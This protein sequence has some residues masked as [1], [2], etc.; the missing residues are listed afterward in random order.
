M[1]SQFDVLAPM[2]LWAREV[3]GVAIGGATEP[4]YV[5]CEDARGKRVNVVLKLRDPGKPWEKPWNL[6]LVRDLVG[7]IIA[8][9]LGLNVPDYA[10][11][12]LDEDFIRSTSKHPAG[13]RISRNT[14]WNFGLLRIDAHLEA[15]EGSPGDWS[16]VLSFDA[17][18]FNGDRQLGNP[19][20]LWDG[21]RLYVIDHGLLAPTWTFRV[22]QVTSSTL[23]GPSRIRQHAGF[24]M[25]QSKHEPYPTHAAAWSSRITAEFLTWL[26]GQVPRT[27]AGSQDVDELFDFLGARATIA[28]MQA[29]ELCS[30]VA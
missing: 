16:P 23:F 4:L 12:E 14:G 22:D 6:C 13:G 18:A 17:L 1:A 24:Q 29:E 25:L 19:N 9:R 26:R 5:E 7:A 2:K 21:L 27:W 28:R 10:L 11:V 20:V 8:R 30:V 15:V 3:K